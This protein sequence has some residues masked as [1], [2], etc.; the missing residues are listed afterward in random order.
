MPV[1]D[2]YTLELTLDVFLV[3][4]SRQLKTSESKRVIGRISHFGS[5]LGC[6]SEIRNFP[7]RRFQEYIEIRNTHINVIQ[8]ICIIKTLNKNF[9]HEKTFFFFLAAILDVMMY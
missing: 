5:H 2:H 3:S 6:H 8:T 7:F 1:E 4:N 9:I